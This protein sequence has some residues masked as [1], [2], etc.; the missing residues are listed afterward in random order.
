[1]RTYHRDR[2]R[3]LSGV[4]FRGH[5]HLGAERFSE[6][7]QD[8]EK[9]LTLPG[10]RLQVLGLLGYGYARGGQRQRAEETIKELMNL[11]RPFGK[12]L[13]ATIA[14][15]GLGRRDDAIASLA[16]AVEARNPQTVNINV[17]PMFD[18]LRSDPRFPGLVRALGLESR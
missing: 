7:I 8:F 9:A 1:V 14:Y 4:L 11:P 2:S 13:M 18:S 3:L 15:A 10:E 6:A 17:E 12:D 16:N 5:A